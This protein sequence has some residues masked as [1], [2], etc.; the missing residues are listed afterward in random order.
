MRLAWLVLSTL[1]VFS[2]NAFADAGQKQTLSVDTSGKP[3][4]KRTLKQEEAVADVAQLESVN[5]EMV[6]MMT[7]DMS[8]KPPYRRSIQRVA[9]AD[10]AQLESAEENQSTDFRGRPPFKRR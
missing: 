10:V 3:P 2:G 8:G 7:V 5:V 1:A 9:V 6:E 4:F